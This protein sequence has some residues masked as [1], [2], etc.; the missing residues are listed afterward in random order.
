[1]LQIH[2]VVAPLANISV[3]VIES[4]Q[5]A[6]KQQDTIT[7]HHNSTVEHMGIQW[8]IKLM[9]SLNSISHHVHQHVEYFVTAD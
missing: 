5:L 4:F 9:V 7:S 3:S 1:M 2:S 6:E 8:T